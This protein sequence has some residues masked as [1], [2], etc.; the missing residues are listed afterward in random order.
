LQLN[1]TGQNKLQFN[2]IAAP[3]IA[4]RKDNQ[5]LP[6]TLARVAAERFLLIN[7]LLILARVAAECFLPKFP[8]P[9]L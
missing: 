6:T 7:A 5:F 8:L 9:P 3:T 4:M 2:L 1:I